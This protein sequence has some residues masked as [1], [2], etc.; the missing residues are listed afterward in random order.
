MQTEIWKPVVGYEG[1][2]EVSNLGRVKSTPKKTN[3][4]F[5][6]IE[7][8]LTQFLSNNHLKVT[9]RKDGREK[10]YYVAVLVAKAFPDICGEW[11]DGYEVHH[12]DKNPLNNSAFNLRCISKEAHYI[13][14]K[15]EVTERLLKASKKPIYQIKNGQVINYYESASE[16][17]RKTGISCKA[18]SNVLRGKNRAKTAGGYEWKYA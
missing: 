13:L 7:T 9:L 1:L 17:Y 4:Q 8:I 16:A 6:G 3:N 14:H 2:F 15:E 5:N 18:I 10:K 12:V 11:L